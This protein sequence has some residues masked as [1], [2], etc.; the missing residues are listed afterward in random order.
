M[1]LDRELS[2]KGG[3]K[4]LHST[5]VFDDLL[6]LRAGDLRS[7]DFTFD[8]R[9]D[10][11]VRY[12]DTPPT[13]RESLVA[14]WRDA[15]GAVYVVE[16]DALITGSAPYDEDGLAG[17]FSFGERSVRLPAHAG[18]NSLIE[19]IV[20]GFK[21]LLLRSVAGPG[22]KLAFVRIRLPR[23]PVLPVEIRYSRRIGEF[24]QGDILV[25]DKPA[26][27]IFFGEWA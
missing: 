23:L 6:S 27:Q 9:T 24:Y 3:R 19:A 20:A 10:H 7:I 16:R 18:D 15:D 2:F 21:A 12:Q 13:A 14:T 22:A 17:G 4:Y 11:Q 25:D 5:T 8:K 26:G 1:N